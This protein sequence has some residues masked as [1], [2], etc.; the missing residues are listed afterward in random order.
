MSVPAHAGAPCV[1]CGGRF[2]RL[3]RSG[4]CLACANLHIRPAL[5]DSSTPYEDDARAQY[6]VACHPDGLTFDEVGQLFGVTRERIRQIEHKALTTF[7]RRALLAGIREEDFLEV[8]AT[9]AEGRITHGLPPADARP[10][11]PSAPAPSALP[12]PRPEVYVTKPAK[13]YQHDDRDLSVGAWAKEPDVVARGLSENTIRMRLKN[14]WSVADALTKPLAS[15]GPRPRST[16]SKPKAKPAA[17]VATNGDEAL[18]RALD[19]VEKSHDELWAELGKLARAGNTL[20][21]LL[22]I[23]RRWEEEA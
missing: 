21:D 8:L 15:S 11:P 18:R 17:T 14:G 12:A 13:T 9:K 2:I 10:A 16:A 19:A 1:I 3:S 6:V 4:R 5:I 23:E 22:R 20:C 7:R